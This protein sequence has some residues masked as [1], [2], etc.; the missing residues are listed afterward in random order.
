M[1]MPVFLN[2]NRINCSFGIIAGPKILST[3]NI[4]QIFWQEFTQESSVGTS[5]STMVTATLVHHLEG[6]IVLIMN[7][8]ISPILYL[9]NMDLPHMVRSLTIALTI[10]FKP[11]F[12]VKMKIRQT[13]VKNR[14]RST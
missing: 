13:V 11:M 3:Q 2:K 14:K 4:V 1:I 9:R 5:G 12:F 10:T 6:P 7:D 8:A